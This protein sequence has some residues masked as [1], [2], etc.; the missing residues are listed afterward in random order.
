MNNRTLYVTIKTNYILMK[1]YRFQLNIFCLFFCMLSYN[2]SFAQC[3][4]KHFFKEHK[5]SI[6][7]YKLDSYTENEISYDQKSKKMEVVF[8]TYSGEYNKL[9]FCG[10]NLPTAVK[11]GVYDKNM[12]AK[13]RNEY[14]TG[15]LSQ[16]VSSTEP[17]ETTKPGTYYI[18]FDIPPFIADSTST[19][20]KTKACIVTLIGYKEVKKK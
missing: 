4:P 12:R 1:N 3:K 16:G 19:N 14:F 17:F 10:D 20:I 9:I 15:E 2:F 7:P 5:N 13:K 18:Q 11:V 8:T 6:K